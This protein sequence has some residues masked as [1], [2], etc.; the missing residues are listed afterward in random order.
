MAAEVRVQ[1]S[2]TFRRAYKRLHPKQKAGV[3]DAVAEIVRD[4]S[5]GEA[6]RGGIWPEYMFTSSN[7]VGSSPCLPMNMT[8][9]TRLLLLLGSHENFSRDLKR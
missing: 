5:G 3:D 9:Q 1:Q 4:P 2:A 6:K 8:P 7:A